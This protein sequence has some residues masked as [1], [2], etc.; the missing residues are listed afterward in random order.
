[1][2]GVRP[3][4][5]L[6]S[7][8]RSSRSWG[9]RLWQ[10]GPSAGRPIRTGPERRR[11]HGAQEEVGMSDETRDAIERFHDALNSHDI[12]ALGLA[13]HEGCVFETTDPPDGTRH[14]GR[15]AVLAACQEFFAQSPE[16]RF[17]MED[18]VTVDDRAFVRWRYE[19]GEGH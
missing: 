19:W 17:T 6:R 16:A 1:M 5:R 11:H 7:W 18:I 2:T 9:R 15:E 12:D 14:I 4:S 3:A 13:V 8:S 10:S